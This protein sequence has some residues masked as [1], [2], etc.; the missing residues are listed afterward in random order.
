MND[1]SAD[2][3]EVLSLFPLTGV[4]L[5]PRASL[6]L[7][8]FE[9]RYLDMASAAMAGDGMIGIV[10]P[11]I[12]EGEPI[13]PETPLYDIGCVGKIVSFNETTDGRNLISLA[14]VSRFKIIKEI[15]TDRTYRSAE[16]SY[17]FFQNDLLPGE[18]SLERGRRFTAIRAY[19]DYKNIQTDWDVIKNATDEAVVSSLAMGCPFEAVE[20][21]ALL[22]CCDLKARSELLTSLMEMAVKESGVLTTPTTQ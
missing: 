16:V 5:L 22:E 13:S 21:Q 12:P 11:Q 9:R 6:P 15:N 10:Q 1:E 4:L 17:S 20:K 14:G 8:I 7:N 18:I 2:L 3:P 19:F